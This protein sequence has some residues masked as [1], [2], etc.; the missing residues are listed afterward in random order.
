M[1]LGRSFR[2][3]GDF[4]ILM[5]SGAQGSQEGERQV[6]SEAGLSRR[7][8]LG[9]ACVRAEGLGMPTPAGAQRII[10]GF[11]RRRTWSRRI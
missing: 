2:Y 1:K 9:A 6:W 7:E 5:M 3:S 10:L 8:R 4:R 11:P